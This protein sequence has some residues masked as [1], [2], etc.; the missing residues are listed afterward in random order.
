MSLINNMLK[1]LEKRKNQPQPVPFIT[2]A[3]AKPRIAITLRKEHWIVILAFTC[4]LL[5]LL[6][7]LF[8]Y[9]HW[10]KTPSPLT[11]LPTQSYNNKPASIAQTDRSWLEP[12]VITGITLQVKDNI[13]ELSLLLN[14]AALYRLSADDLHNQITLTIEHA[15]LQAALP[16]TTYLNTAIRQLT[17]SSHNSDTVL[18]LTLHPDATI[19]YVNLNADDKNP[20][21]VVAIEYRSMNSHHINS[22]IPTQ[23]KAPAMQS[24]LREQY[25]TALKAAEKGEFTFAITSLSALIKT[26]PHY[27]EARASLVALLL[28]QGHYHR[29]ERIIEEGLK[30]DAGYTPFIEL[31]ARILTATGK[32]KAAI[33]LLQN[34][35]PPMT[36]NPEYHAFL[37]AL[38][39]RTDNDRLAVNIYRHLLALNAHNGNWW[40]GLGVSLDKLE[41]RQAAVDAFT[42]A[43]SEGH[44]NLASISYLQKRLHSLQG[45]NDA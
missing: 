22:M 7:A 29:A 4:V 1:D 33:A 25:Q 13:T 15:N 38:Y 10:R 16:L 27:K 5:S 21:L 36:D 39:A 26:D 3:N 20:E 32:I 42:K 23:I 12:A 14:H 43:M 45:D 8:I 31:K 44:L 41:Q 11:F 37:A 24:L 28:D 9:K 19:K 40:F 30:T 17:S 34:A 18:H 35:A 2:I 6:G